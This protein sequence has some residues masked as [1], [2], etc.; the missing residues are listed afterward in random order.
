[1]SAGGPDLREG[2]ARGWKQAHG[3]QE[4]GRIQGNNQR[5]RST[6]NGMISRGPNP[7]E[8]SRALELRDR[9]SRARALGT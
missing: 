2:H 4:L 8:G 3:V 1:M 6:A 9:H 5:H 7:R